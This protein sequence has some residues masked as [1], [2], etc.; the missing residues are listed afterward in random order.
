MHE[1]SY[2]KP[3]KPSQPVKAGKGIEMGYGEQV[4]VVCGLTIVFIFGAGLV[5]CVGSW[6]WFNWTT[7]NDK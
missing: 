2:L 5:A 1:A 7:R 3:T 4:M 6:A